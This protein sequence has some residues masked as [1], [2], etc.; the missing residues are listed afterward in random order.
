MTTVAQQVTVTF[1]PFEEPDWAWMP[2]ES[3]HQFIRIRVVDADIAA[4]AR[5]KEMSTVRVPDSL[6]Y[7]PMDFQGKLDSIFYQVENF[8]SFTGADG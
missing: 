7:F 4:I 8:H 2:N 1:S 5:S 3:E 6:A